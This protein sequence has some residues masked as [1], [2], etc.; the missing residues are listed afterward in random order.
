MFK[1]YERRRAAVKMFFERVQKCAPISADLRRTAINGGYWLVS[2]VV[3]GVIL[4]AWR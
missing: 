3:M 2:F 1:D 4:G